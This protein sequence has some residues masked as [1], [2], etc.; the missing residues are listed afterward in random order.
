MFKAVAVS[1]RYTFPNELVSNG[2]TTFHS[3]PVIPVPLQL[4]SSPKK[5]LDLG[6][7]LFELPRDLT[8]LAASY[9]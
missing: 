7:L 2:Y 5:L 1:D 4:G 6:S 3:F 8:K 9:A